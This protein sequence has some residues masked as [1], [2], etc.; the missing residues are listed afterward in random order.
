MI[1]EK[2]M[3]L[4]LAIGIL[5]VF[6]LIASGQDPTSTRV[7]NSETVS[8]EEIRGL[9]KS[10][11]TRNKS[12]VLSINN[13]NVTISGSKLKRLPKVGTTIRLTP[14]AGKY[15]Y[16]SC[17]ECNGVCPGVCFMTASMNCR[18]YLEHL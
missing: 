17:E 15:I 2:L 10:V 6:P 3:N 1:M 7:I 12:Y 4:F 18:C 16:A 9:V 8:P 14:V 11:D 13:E 5:I